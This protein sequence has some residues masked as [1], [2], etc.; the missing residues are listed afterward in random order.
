MKIHFL[1]KRL[2]EWIHVNERLP[3]KDEMKSKDGFPSSYQYFK[4]LGVKR[5]NE[6]LEYFG[7]KST[8]RLWTTDEIKY[9]KENWINYTDDKM[10]KVLKRSK[11]AIRFK[12][13]ELE[14]LRQGTKQSWQ[15]WEEDFLINN[16]YDAE[17]SVIEATLAH[18]KWETIRAYATKQLKLR[19]KNHLHKYQTGDGNRICEMCEEVFPENTHYFYKDGNGYRIKCINCYNIYQEQKARENG[20]LT[21]KLKQ[22]KFEDG[23]SKC[24]CC[25]EWKSLSEFNMSSN[26]RQSVRRYCLKCD[27]EYLKKYHLIRRYGE[28]NYE[29]AYRAAVA[30]HTDSK[31]NIWDSKDEVYIANWLMKNDYIVERGPFYKNIFEYDESR[32]IF[33]FLIKKGNRV[34]IVEYFGLWNIKA[35]HGYLFRYTKK[36]KKKIKLLYK[37]RDKF[38][39]IIL[40]KNDLLNLAEALEDKIIK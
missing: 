5:W 24:S 8:L 34:Y 19:R 29:L 32:R 35:T 4:V 39:F 6:V 23:L 30:E 3:K 9:I 38:N 33:D 22:E 16:F 2:D 20:V 36:A 31:G 18:R 12:R 14:L 15:Q 26:V 37:H 27:K 11:N 28:A 10:A 21:R 1:K 40:F 25:G 17:Q 7:Y 13:L